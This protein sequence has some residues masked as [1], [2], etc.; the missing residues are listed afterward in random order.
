MI[1]SR[2][3]IYCLEGNWSNQPSSKLSIK[4]ILDLL[5]MTSKVKYIYNKCQTKNEFL[6]HLERFTNKT[7]KN[8]PVLYIAFH[9]RTNRIYTG[10]EEITLQEISNLLEGKLEGKIVHFGS[11]STLRIADSKISDFILRTK[12][13]FISGYKKDVDFICSTAFELLF[14]EYLQNCAIAYKLDKKITSQFY[15]LKRKFNFKIYE[16]THAPNY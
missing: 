6:F 8:Y 7:Y 5:Y 12:C 11:C 3:N 1:E 14:F 2:K 16:K 9:G 4:P 15:S 10:S 13:N